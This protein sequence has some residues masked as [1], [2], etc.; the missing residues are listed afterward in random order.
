[1]LGRMGVW[2]C[3]GLER[4]SRVSDQMTAQGSDGASVLVTHSAVLD[5]SCAAE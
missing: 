2:D 1:M 5:R 3:G 4:M